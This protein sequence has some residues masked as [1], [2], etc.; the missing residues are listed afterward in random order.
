MLNVLT[1]FFGM[2]SRVGDY[3]LA[4]LA[5]GFLFLPAAGIALFPPEPPEQQPLSAPTLENPK[6]ESLAF[7]PIQRHAPR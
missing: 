3:R 4:L 2:F 7:S 1:V 6:D 5:A